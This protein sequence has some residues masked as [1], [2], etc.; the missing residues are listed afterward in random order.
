MCSSDLQS[1][2]LEEMNPKIARLAVDAGMGVTR[3]GTRVMEEA[4]RRRQNDTV[5]QLLEK[6]RVSGDS[7]KK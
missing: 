7:E 3:L 1:Q 2:S 4:F 5:G 6:L